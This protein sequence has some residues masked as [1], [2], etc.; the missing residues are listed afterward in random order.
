M[1]LPE[2]GLLSVAPPKEAEETPTP[3][4]ATQKQIVEHFAAIGA[5]SLTDKGLNFTEHKRWYGPDYI[6]FPGAF[7]AET[8]QEKGELERISK[9]RVFLTEDPKWIKD[10]RE[11]ML[12]PNDPIFVFFETG[13][14]KDDPELKELDIRFAVKKEQFG[15]IISGYNNSLKES[16]IEEQRLLAERFYCANGHGDPD[17]FLPLKDNF[18]ALEKAYSEKTGIKPLRP[19]EVENAEGRIRVLQPEIKDGEKEIELFES[20]KKS[21]IEVYDIYIAKDLGGGAEKLR[22]QG[23]KVT[24]LDNEGCEI[25]KEVVFDPLHKQPKQIRLFE[26]SFLPK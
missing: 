11:V 21:G 24:V 23:F 8:E 22:E 5:I 3:Y 25:K 6:D 16:A 18:G 14:F 9:G 26:N 19:E 20:L 7:G 2:R 10:R 1:P 15:K 12:N 13:E 17:Y 4:S